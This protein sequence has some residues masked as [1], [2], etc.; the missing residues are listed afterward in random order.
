MF[1]VNKYWLT[2]KVPNTAPAGT[3]TFVIISRTKGRPIFI[4]A[5]TNK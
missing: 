1:D 3:I 2:V 4:C 5:I